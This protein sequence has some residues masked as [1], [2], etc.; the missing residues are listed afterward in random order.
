M[1]MA[2]CK[3][4]L[5]KSFLLLFHFYLTARK[6][7]NHNYLML[8]V[9]FHSIVS[10]YLLEFGTKKHPQN[11]NQGKRQ[12]RHFGMVNLKLVEI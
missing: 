12:N 7:L 6:Y 10:K 3:S 11:K 8:R 4:L 5:F 1:Q 2:N 9:F